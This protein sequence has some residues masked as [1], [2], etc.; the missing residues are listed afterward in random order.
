MDFCAEF[1]SLTVHGN[2]EIKPIIIAEHYELAVKT[3]Q[4]TP[5]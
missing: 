1:L 2:I 3:P 4:H 5:H